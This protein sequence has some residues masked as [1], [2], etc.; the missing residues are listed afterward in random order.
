MMAV[1]THRAC[2]LRG[3]AAGPVDLQAK[4]LPSRDFNTA[5]TPDFVDPFFLEGG[6][7]S[8]EGHGTRNRGGEEARCD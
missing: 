2:D 6:G 1:R 7:S 5:I 3:G 4:F 8:R